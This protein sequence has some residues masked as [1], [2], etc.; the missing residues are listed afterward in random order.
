MAIPFHPARST[1]AA[2]ISTSPATSRTWSR[3]RITPDITTRYRRRRT[4]TGNLVFRIKYAY[5]QFN[6]DD[7]TDW[8]GSWVRL[9]IQQTPYVDY[10]EG[11]YRYR[12]QGNIFEEREAV[13]GN[14][15]SSDAGVVVP[16]QPSGNYGEVHVGVYNGEGYSKSKRTTRRRS[17]SA[18]RF[19]RWRVARSRRA[20]FGVT[21][22]YDADHYVRN[23]ERTRF[24]A[25]ATFE[26]T[27]FNAG[28]DYLNAKDQPSVNQTDIKSK[29]WS[30]WVTPFFKEK[31]NGL[32]ALLRL[33]RFK[34]DV[35]TAGKANQERQRA[36]AGVAYW[37]PHPGGAATA[38]VMLDFE[39]L[40]FDQ[41]P[42]GAANA[43]QQRIAIHGLLSF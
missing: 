26:H 23:G 2:P 43:T 37:F 3:F 38:S 19:G 39:Q 9:G 27:R 25:N 15:T 20:D 40:K 34:P 1:S 36:I 4:L 31:G 17:S 21:A 30:G 5:A 29:G 11:I 24:V 41:F 8:K 10:D 33:D 7:W 14:L 6:L 13:G 32:E 18:A 16:H 35:T 12:F 28:F 42:S 22:F